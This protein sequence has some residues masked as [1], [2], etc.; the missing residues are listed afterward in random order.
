MHVC[1]QYTLS[2][3][4]SCG[5]EQIGKQRFVLNQS[6]QKKIGEGKHQ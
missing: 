3:A 6:R 4:A 1:T 5:E 2:I